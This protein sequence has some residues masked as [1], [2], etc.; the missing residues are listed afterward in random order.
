MHDVN[1]VIVN[2][3]AKDQVDT[4][5]SSLFFDIKNCPLNIH[6]TV[7]DNGSDDQIEQVLKDKYV[8]IKFIR[9]KE[10]M[11]FAKAQNSGLAETQAKYHLVLNPDTVFSPNHNTIQKLYDFMEANPKAGI[12]GP[13]IVYPDGTLQNSCYRFPKFLQPLYSR[14]VLGKISSGKKT[15]DHYFMR[16]FEH[17][18]TIP[19]DWIMGAAM[20]VRQKAIDGIGRFD[21]RFW[22]YAEDSD[23]CR[24]MWEKKW[25]VYYVHDII[26]KHEHG[27]GSAKVPGIAKSLLKNKLARAHLKSWLQYMWKWR[28]THRCYS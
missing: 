22:M 12:A 18:E 19:V 10:N 28:K 17:D 8:N 6:I 25:L 21:E 1:V 3:Q 13:K 2:Y 24:R 23:W 15:A 4:C 27:R 7:V 9:H 11:G 26:I 20:F 16:D 14:T 5:L